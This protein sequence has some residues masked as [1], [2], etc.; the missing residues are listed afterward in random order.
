MELHE[1]IRSLRPIGEEPLRIVAPG[2][3]PGTASG[4]FPGSAPARGVSECILPE[5]P[6]SECETLGAI[7]PLQ[8]RIVAGAGT[9]VRL[10]VLHT[11][12]MAT[13]IELV[14]EVGASIALTEIFTAGAAA[15]LSIRQA[16]SSRTHLTLVELAGAEVH[17]TTDLAG[18]G[19]RCEQQALLLVG[20]EEQG[21]LTLRTNHLVPDCTSRAQVRGVAGG[22]ATGTFRGLVYVA[23]DAQ[24]TDAGQQCRNVLLNDTARID[25]QPQL[26][27][28]ADDVQCTH[29]A[30][31][32]LLD[33]DA[34]FYMRQRGLD[35]RQARQLQLTGFVSELLQGC[36]PEPLCDALTAAVG[37]RLKML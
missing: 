37:E 8:V 10:A 18:G 34:I 31:V 5:S 33:R 25:A 20:G 29:G 19:A 4:C 2:K 22:R 26:E 16:A 21:L 24:R 11:Q 12:P 27:I 17:G 3:M 14:A 6:A 1:I 15:E 35:E 7:D 13:H 36:S 32:G 28:Y 23:P 9:S 30:T